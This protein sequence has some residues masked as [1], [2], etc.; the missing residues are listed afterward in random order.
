MHPFPH[1]G[2]LGK[3]AGILFRNLTF[4]YIQYLVC[5]QVLP[6]NLQHGQVEYKEKQ[7]MVAMQQ[8][9]GQTNQQNPQNQQTT[10][11]NGDSYCRQIA[12]DFSDSI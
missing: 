10:L 9:Q 7:K 4:Y 1:F 3:S 8:Q 5:P 2:P 11:T 12:I 6:V